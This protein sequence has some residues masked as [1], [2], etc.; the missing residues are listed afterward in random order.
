MSFC[1]S[2]DQTFKSSFCNHY[3]FFKVL[4]KSGRGGGGGAGAGFRASLHFDLKI[5]KGT[6]QAKGA[7]VEALKLIKRLV[8]ERSLYYRI[9]CFYFVTVVQ[10]SQK[11]LL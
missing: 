9:R 8:P 7:R 11:H 6:I 2:A 5:V 4:K 10:S 1:N 3:V